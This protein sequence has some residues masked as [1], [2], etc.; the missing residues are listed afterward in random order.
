MQ[1]S[2]FI[3]LVSNGKRLREVAEAAD[4][5]EDAGLLQY[6]KTLDS[7]E[8][9]LT[10]LKTS[11]QQFYMNILNGDF[12][13]GIIDKVTLLID[14]FN[15]LGTTSG[16]I[17]LVSLV[18]GAKSITGSKGILGEQAGLLSLFSKKDKA[19]PAVS[20][21]SGQGAQVASQAASK[22]ATV[23]GIIGGIGGAGAQAL[24]AY[25]TSQDNI[26][27]AAWANTAGSALTGLSMGSMFG[28]AG[29]LL[30]AI[31]GGI[32]GVISNWDSLINGELVNAQ[33]RIETAQKNL[34]NTKIKR[35]ES[36]TKNK[37]L[38]SYEKKLTDL[39]KE[40]FSSSDKQEEW[41][42]LN[43]EIIEQYP[44]LLKAYDLEG[45]ALVD[46]GKLQEQITDSK[47]ES[48]ELTRQEHEEQVGIYEQQRELYANSTVSTGYESWSR[49]TSTDTANNS[50]RGTVAK[51]MAMWESALNG[52]WW[53]EIKKNMKNSIQN[54]M[55]T[56]GIDDSTW[57]YSWF[58]DGY[59][60][61]EQD[62]LT[63]INE[64]NAA[65]YRRADAYVKSAQYQ[66]NLANPETGKR[67]G[68]FSRLVTWDKNN[69]D[70]GLSNSV[71]YQLMQTQGWTSQDLLTA[72]QLQKSNGLS[73][74]DVLN[75]SKSDLLNSTA[76]VLRD[77]DYFVEKD[78]EYTLSTKAGRDLTKLDNLASLGTSIIAEQYAAQAA[79]NA[80]LVNNATD[81]RTAQSFSPINTLLNN[82]SQRIFDGQTDLSTSRKDYTEPMVEAIAAYNSWLESLDPKQAQQAASIAENLR[83][84]N[85]SSMLSALQEL[86]LDTSNDIAADYATA[87]QA[88]AVDVQSRAANNL[89]GNTGVRSQVGTYEE[90]LQNQEAGYQDDT[91]EN[92]QRYLKQLQEKLQE[93][94]F[95]D[96]E[97]ASIIL[98][99][100]LNTLDA[101]NT[102]Y[103]ELDTRANDVTSSELSRKIANNAK[104]V[105]TNLQYE[106]SSTDAN[107]QRNGTIFGINLAELNDAAYNAL[108]DV[109][110]SDSYGTSDWEAEVKAW[111]RK[112]GK[113]DQVTEALKDYQEIAYDNFVTASSAV[114]DNLTAS[115]E[116]LDDYAKKQ[117]SG[118]TF[119]EAEKLQKKLESAGLDKSFGELFEVDE[120]GLL[121]LTNFSEAMMALKG[122][123]KNS[124]AKAAHV[125]GSLQTLFENNEK[126]LQDFVNTDVDNITKQLSN[127]N[128]YYQWGLDKSEIDS[129]A[130]QIAAVSDQGEEAVRS[131]IE[132][133]AEKYQLGMEWVETMVSESSKTDALKKFQKKKITAYDKFQATLTLSKTGRNTTVN[134][135]KD[136]LKT[137]DATA[138]QIEATDAYLNEAVGAN[139]G[140]LVDELGRF[141][142]SEWGQEQWQGLFHAMGYEEEK[143][144]QLAQ[145]YYNNSIQEQIRAF[146]DSGTSLGENIGQRLASGK[147]IE[148]YDISQAF[149]EEDYNKLVEKFNES[150]YADAFSLE[151]I[152]NGTLL[153]DNNNKLHYGS[154]GN[155]SASRAA[156]LKDIFGKNNEELETFIEN[157]D[158]ALSD[159]IAEETNN[160]LDLQLSS[161]TFE[162]LTSTEAMQLSAAQKAGK[163]FIDHVSNW[164]SRSIQERLDAISTTLENYQ[165]S[166]QLTEE[167]QFTKFSESFATIIEKTYQ[168]E[169]KDAY[170]SAIQPLEEGSTSI[171]AADLATLGTRLFGQEKAANILNYVTQ[172]SD[173]T[174]AILN[175]VFADKDLKLHGGELAALKE[176]Y[177]ST[178]LDNVSS[179]MEDIADA[180]AR[181]RSKLKPT[182]IQDFFKSVG[183]EISYQDASTYL[184]ESTQTLLNRMAEALRTAGIPE[185]DVSKKLAELQA[186]VLDAIIETISNVAGNISEGIEGT[187]SAENYNALR[188]QYGLTGLGSTISGKGVT[189]G[190]KDQQDLITSI[191]STALANGLGGADT[192]QVLWDELRGSK[193]LFSNYQEVQD[194]AKQAQETYAKQQRALEIHNRSRERERM[195]LDEQAEKLLANSYQSTI[196]NKQLDGII[197][198]KD[199]IDAAAAAEEEAANNAKIW[200][201]ALSQVASIAIL[202]PDDPIFNFMDQEVAGGLTK[203]FDNFVS[204]IDSVK[205]SFDSLKAAGKDGYI[206]YQDFYNMM[207]FLDNATERFQARGEE[208][209]AGLAKFQEILNASGKTYEQFVNSVVENT[210]KYGKVN[211][212]GIAAEM[213]ISVDAAMS[214]MKEGMVD[215]LKDVA[216][217]QIQYLSGLEKML[218]ALTA[219]EA[220][221]SIGAE[222]S[223]KFDIDGNGAEDVV[224]ITDFWENYQKLKDD[225]VKQAEYILAFRTALEGAGESGQALINALWGDGN[226]SSFDAL[227][228]NSL[229]NGLADGT[230]D[231]NAV[232]P[233]LTNL[234]QGNATALAEGLWAAV[235]S[236][237]S[238]DDIFTYDESGDINGIQAG[239]EEYAQQVINT[240]LGIA[241]DPSTYSNLKESDTL[242]FTEAAQKGIATALTDEQG[243]AIGGYEIDIPSEAKIHYQVTSGSDSYYTV[244]SFE[245][246]NPNSD[247]GKAKIVE[248]LNS[249]LNLKGQEV[250]VDQDITVDTNGKLI[251]STKN[252]TTDT[253]DIQATIATISSDIHSLVETIN[254]EPIQFQISS[255]EAVTA[256]TSVNDILST[257][258]SNA[259]GL[260]NIAAA[261]ADIAARAGNAESQLDR[262]AGELKEIAGRT[263]D[264]GSGLQLNINNDSLSTLTTA[265]AYLNSQEVPK[266]TFDADGDK[267]KE[268]A[269][270]VKKYIASVDTSHSTIFNA[271]VG[272]VAS[273]VNKVSQLIS[274][275]K[276]N[277]PISFSGSVRIGKSS[278]DIAT[279]V[280]G[281]GK[282]IA[283]TEF[284]G[285][286]DG[287]ALVNGQ[288]YGA[289]LAGKTLV[290][291][292]G[293]ELAVYDNKYHLLGED[294]AEFV[295]L[296]SDAI[297]FNHLQTQGII[298][299]KVDKIRG[300]Q[301]NAAYKHATMYTG[302]ALVEGNAFASGIGSALSAVRR[303]KSVWQGLLN[304]LSIADLTNGGG[305]G[306][307]GGGKNASLKPYIADLQEWYN[308]SRQIVDLENRINTL[309][310]QRNNLSKGFDQGAAYLRNLKE[311]QAL[312]EDQLNTQRDLYRYQQD[313][314]KRQADAINDSSNWISK[315]YKVGADGVLQYIEGNETNGGKG[316]LEVLQ[317]LNDMGDNPERYTIKDQ[318]AWIEEVTNG[319]F[320]RG[321]TWEEGQTEDENGKTV[322]NGEYTKKEWTD[323]EYVQEFF[324]ALQ[325]PIDDYDGLRDSVQETEE[326]LESLAEEIQKVNDEIRDN[327][328]EVSQMIY[329]AIVQVKEKVIKD[330]KESNKLITDANKAYADSI[331][332]AITKEK[333]QYST[334]QNISE[335]ETLQRQLSLLRR[336][337]G[338]ASEIQSLEKTISE[339]LK[340]EYFQKQE[341]ALEVIKDANTKQTELMEQQVQLLQDTLD[342]EK[343]NGILWT[344]VYEIMDQGNAFMLDFLSGA[345]ADSFLEKANLEQK[346]MLEEWAFKIGLYSENE[347]S[348]MLSNKY[349]E[350]TFE[351]LKGNTS[352]ASKWKEGYKNVYDSVDA[353]TR[354]GWDRDYL[355]TYNSYMLK[356]IN[357]Q[358]SNEQIAAAQKEASRLAEQTFFEHIAQEKKRRED[359]EKAK[360]QISGSG[361]SGGSGGSSGGGSSSTKKTSTTRYYWKNSVTGESGYASS[362]S[363]AEGKVQE[364]Y[365][366]WAKNAGGTLAGSYSKSTIN[367]KIAEDKKKV[368]RSRKTGGSA[369]NTGL[370]MLHGTQ[371]NP[372]YI[373]NANQTRGLEQLVSFT[374]KNPD[375]VNVLKAHY[376]SFAGNLASQNYTTSNSNSI[377]ISDGAIQ[378]SVAKLNDSYDIEDI[379]ND[380][381]DR[382]YSIAAKSSSRSVS[383]R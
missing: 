244:E 201:Q 251:F 329:D 279:V 102:A 155:T 376:D 240:M 305:G 290:G 355:D 381:M 35:A 112:Y 253:E 374:Q 32:A 157:Y 149:S 148:S 211:I 336:S 9:K 127:Y 198:Q 53:A 108:Q 360:N 16:M 254:G 247:D 64:V 27:A 338:S 226:F 150:I 21:A 56:L 72:A 176:R 296:P 192:A 196:I 358:S 294:G 262:V 114:Y 8:T 284:T 69:G 109:I 11:F 162:N 59:D 285:N 255:D 314:L 325:E 273:V 88:E 308:L 228:V 232:L 55:A 175:D 49:L 26:N 229:A 371:E 359:N 81:Q 347:R 51:N 79:A 378:I 265:L 315:F 220:I 38:L 136:Y 77:F 309:V 369:T 137:I 234:L 133:Y 106:Y 266:I 219:L 7:L 73:V 46:L 58:G 158:S 278:G 340:D 190:L 164:A 354:T 276:T 123:D 189:L 43:N 346:K 197:Q 85:L 327:E 382:M 169:L 179:S 117:D 33:A 216:K 37:N 324:S 80:I 104:D 300:T 297:V 28:P 95:S 126:A 14:S 24:S 82:R 195:A 348:T 39:Q 350:P 339:K 210:D 293:P 160:L 223:F 66:E 286:V 231:L 62:Y 144:M 375:F 159:S 379:S 295:N 151:D 130:N 212:G 145:E 321:F 206:G 317:E 119:E 6:S 161:L 366:K 41:I 263:N 209:P 330:L 287:K 257:I 303:A 221:G 30:G 40:R 260:L 343:E 289:T 224:Q 370:Y 89:M 23:G 113:E 103:T 225:Q 312:L 342:Y 248:A 29:M 142:T 105:L 17:A 163:T 147:K 222:F 91:Y 146:E 335:R 230:L 34:E 44:E 252:M 364:S 110:Y 203:N 356:N 18:K 283:T 301:L 218:E 237:H 186:L 280:T 233:Q 90:W 320:K 4:N 246:F 298:D 245:G 227:L 380:I 345:G 67:A 111:G 92:R 173:G 193:G 250:D 107:G 292:L 277:I 178:L 239:M 13:K 63:G 281:G 362:K 135:V 275:V 167:E 138:A 274:S 326:K 337:G 187:L 70:A 377:N 68:L 183:Q 319:Q 208:L 101:F 182:D 291:E 61:W 5:S 83:D 269:E 120:D 140:E 270:E 352:D 132:S 261:L 236:K 302:N 152:F 154:D 306:G 99:S 98:N 129:L 242:A 243:K 334:N 54:S 365:N 171:S 367:S 271:Y 205:S 97:L 131:T 282:R 373:L 267:V 170:N 139:G 12:F 87:W 258:I 153:T 264:I 1:Q 50:M 323:E 172:L 84:Y 215:G 191:Y 304:S 202:D 116:E 235:N 217:Q 15:K 184:N 357:G 207:D 353:A 165:G 214:M 115:Q 259:Q 181:D 299:G 188:Q 121:V 118:F 48:L 122:K 71:L 318:V 19:T 372:E 20:A 349:A 100:D 332:N 3:A 10:N 168:T 331:Q 363:A 124:L 94:V 180:F 93:S 22:F 288:T 141:N 143:A 78:G 134:D 96:N 241:T 333:N 268:V 128:T 213:G 307:G 204:S 272:N 174:F 344:K 166:G 368:R 86:G 156:I 185:N 125:Y 57:D 42:S 238:F 313:E 249:V 194:E 76:A 311:S 256:L 31:G 2:R 177:T 351:T 45:N 75:D 60:N 199:A 25:Y 328:I 316:A 74:E 200:A 361:G 47:K 322:G 36:T 310:A 65:F 341:D 52:G 383:R